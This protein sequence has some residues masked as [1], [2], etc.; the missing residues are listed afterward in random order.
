MLYAVF[1]IF[2][3]SYFK[4]VMVRTF[5]YS[6]VAFPHLQRHSQKATMKIKHTGICL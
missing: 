6:R 1:S 2:A 3:E 5:E 4:Q